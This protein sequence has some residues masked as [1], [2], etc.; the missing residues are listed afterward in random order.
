MGNVRK[1]VLCYERDAETCLRVL[2]APPLENDVVLPNGTRLTAKAADWLRGQGCS[3]C[4]T[5]TPGGGTGRMR[6]SLYYNNSARGLEAYPPEPNGWQGN[7]H[8]VDGD[9]ALSLSAQERLR[10]LLEATLRPPGEM[11]QHDR[12]DELHSRGWGLYWET[13]RDGRL[14]RPGW[15]S[16]AITGYP[17]VCLRDGE[18]WEGLTIRALHEARLMK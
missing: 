4:D 9:V 1:I 15:K 5:G 17:R 11:S 3:V 6:V 18:S 8:L 14:H 13:G 12:E 2:G 7:E 10:E 16:S